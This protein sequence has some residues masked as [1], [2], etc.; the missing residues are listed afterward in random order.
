ML[1]SR[2]RCWLHGD[3][4]WSTL[5]LRGRPFGPSTPLADDPYYCSPS[6]RWSGLCWLPVFATSSLSR[7]RLIWVLWLFSSTWYLP[8]FGVT[9]IAESHMVSSLLRSILLVKDQFRSHIRLKCFLFHIEKSAC[10]GPWLLV[11]SG[12]PCYQSP[13]LECFRP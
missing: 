9:L 11:S 6:L 1:Q 2:A 7:A 3:L 10:L 4:V 12:L 8:P 5:F 13:S